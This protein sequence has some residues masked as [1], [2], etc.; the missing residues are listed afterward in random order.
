MRFRGKTVVVPR[1][2]HPY[3]HHQT[4]LYDFSTG[5]SSRATDLD[6][7]V[8]LTATAAALAVASRAWRSLC[9]SNAEE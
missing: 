8:R 9:V 3:E 2:H 5:P 1:I 7:V 6:R 4:S